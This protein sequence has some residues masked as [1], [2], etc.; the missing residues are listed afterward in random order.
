MTS[1]TAARLQPD[2][3]KAR[4]LEHLA[5]LY[6]TMARAFLDPAPAR[7]VAVGGLSG[8][9][10]ST[11]ARSLAPDVGRPPG[12]V[13]VRSDE[14]R[15]SLHGVAPLERLGTDAYA[16]PISREVYRT[17]QE[18]A[19]EVLR[20]GQS[21]IADA[22]FA[23][24]A[25]RFGVE[26]VAGETSV[27]FLGLWLDVSPDVLVRRV[28]GRGPDASDATPDIVREQ[29]RQDI[30]PLAWRRLE[31][32]SDPQSVTHRALGLVTKLRRSGSRHDQHGT[33]G[34]A[35]HGV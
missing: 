28:E 13:L 17:L 14:I 35:D 8:S 33:G 7:L 19:R 24:P 6:L 31:A 11:L 22:V 21:V 27:R 34:P 5:R 12:A 32:G 29:L 23:R 3:E 4:E 2:R 30:G 25:D 15:K 20:T 26:Q 9:G 10:K 18:R 16:A 1:A